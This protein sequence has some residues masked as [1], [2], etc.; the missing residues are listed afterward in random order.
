MK[1]LFP[2]VML[3]T[4]VLTSSLAMAGGSGPEEQSAPTPLA[5]ET[6]GRSA[7]DVLNMLSQRLSLS[8]DQKSLI[9]PILVER[10][11]KIQAVL[12]DASLRRRQK[13]GQMSGILEDSDKR[14][15]ALLSAEQQKTYAVVE[16]Q[17]KAQLKARHSRTTATA[18]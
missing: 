5:T 3:S 17:V 2:L 8:E 4:S 7:N 10:R 13:M 14:I 9:L 11:Q 15:D 1:L 12:A 6:T 16:Q 18:N